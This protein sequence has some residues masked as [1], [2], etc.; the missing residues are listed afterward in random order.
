MSK[1]VVY[2]AIFG[3]IKDS[4]HTVAIPGDVTLHA[5]VEQV[6]EPTKHASGWTLMPAYWKHPNPRLRARRHKLLS[7]ELYPDHEYSLW[8]DGC[9]TPVCDPGYLIEHYLFDHDICLF[10]HCQRSCLYEEADACLKLK[11]DHPELIRRL[12]DRY[13]QEGYPPDRGLAETT[14]VLR[15]HS[16]KIRRLNEL[17]WK[18]LRANSIRD[19]LSFNYVAWKLG[20]NYQAFEGTRTNNPHF[21]WRPHR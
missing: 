4:L 20:I 10:D 1:I 17:W 16:P 21:E 13:R 7:H 18:E 12:V 2:T 11:K 6:Q 9:L 8:L 5:Y 14:A 3:S 15:R 19:Q